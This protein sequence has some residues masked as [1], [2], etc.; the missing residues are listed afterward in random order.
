MRTLADALGLT[1]PERPRCQTDEYVKLSGRDFAEAV[2]NSVEFRR[3][4]LTG[5]T[6]GC[7]HPTILAKLIDH[8]WGKV[9]ERVEF[10]DKTPRFE[11][12]P[13]EVLQSR[14][15]FAQSLLEHL[16][17]N[18][19]VNAPNPEKDDGPPSSSVH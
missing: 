16:R 18:D 19:E 2:L 4:I 9:T 12:A 11:D 15:K 14:I 13:E 6:L 17:M 8:G 10:E 1:E 5:I 3:Y 7:I